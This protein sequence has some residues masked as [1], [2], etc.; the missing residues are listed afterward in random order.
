MN[1]LHMQIRGQQN[2]KSRSLSDTSYCTQDI[3]K[4]KGSYWY[5]ILSNLDLRARP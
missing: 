4:R 1:S 3:K 2:S 5:R